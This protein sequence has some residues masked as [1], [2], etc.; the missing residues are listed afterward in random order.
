MRHAP[1]L[2]LLLLPGLGAE[3]A[4]GQSLPADFGQ[5]APGF[6]DDFIG[7]ARNP[8]WVASPARQDA[9]V[10]AN[11]V[12]Q[13]AVRRGDPN[14]L[15]FQAD[16]YD[17]TRQ[18]VLARVRLRRFAGGANARAGIG[19]GVDAE[20]SQ[21]INL[22]FVQFET[23]SPYAQGTWGRQF[24]LIDDVRAWGPPGL[25]AGWET[26]TWYWLRLRQTGAGA[27][28]PNVLG[29]AWPADG[30][31]PEPSAWQLSWS[32]P[33]RSGL[34]GILGGSG[35]ESDF[36]VDYFLLKAAGLPLI[37]L[38]P[39][40]LFFK[41]PEDVVLRPGQAATFQLAAS[42]SGGRSHQWQ[43]ARPGPVQF[44]DIPGATEA[45][46]TT[47]PLQAADHGTRYRCLVAVESGRVATR[48][49]TVTV[50]AQPPKLVSART[51]GRSQQVTVVFDEPVSGDPGTPGGLG[52][53]SLAPGIPVLG[54]SPGRQ[55]G[56]L[57]LATSPLPAGATHTLTVSGLRDSAGN[58]I[59]PDSRIAIDLS[60]E[61]PEDY[62]TLVAG[63][64]DD[65]EAPQPVAGWKAIP[66]GSAAL[67]QAEGRLKLRPLGSGAS[68]LVYQGAAYDAVEQ[69]VLVRVRLAAVSG[70][71]A[72]AG[73]S[74]GVDPAS[75]EGL[76]FSFRE[77]DQ[78]GI[79]G[80]QFGLVDDRL[81]WG[82]PVADLPWEA[83]AWYW[84]RLRQTRGATAGIAVLS[85]KAWPADG[86]VREP[87]EWQAV[88]KHSCRAGLAG[89][90][91][92]NAAA[93]AGLEV[94]YLLIKAPGLPS[95]KV[96][97]HAFSLVPERR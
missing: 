52:R 29:K 87:S 77:H 40:L 89:L 14:H 27:G 90:L 82:P 30:A 86:L 34:A 1:L 88:W 16:G 8:H 31:S 48:A 12:L 46:Y 63:Y 93:A 58:E 57:E 26:N 79:F 60:V 54:I 24:K 17:A 20:T 19:V 73:A 66:A 13:V 69:E 92:P 38:G 78:A 9:Y 22:L 55:P 15:L 45:S 43:S 4:A 47:V 64:Q 49:A 11:G 74:V 67:E 6:Q 37:R 33:A 97:P 68:H 59:A 44:L 94:D 5:T 85:A 39:Q 72:R 84:L 61:V 41:E 2:A 75:G 71:P 7:N 91:G 81:A 21:G 80:R 28:Q 83:G 42:G 23:G 32:R 65:F 50:D 18:E 10:Q 62:G 36:E 56:I 3:R 53:F 70:S 95:I 35:A 76:N 51:L 25:A 96:A